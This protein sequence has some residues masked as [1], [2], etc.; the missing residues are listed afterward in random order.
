[1]KASLDKDSSDKD[2]ITCT[3]FRRRILEETNM[4]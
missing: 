1:M 3:Q 2:R 4:L